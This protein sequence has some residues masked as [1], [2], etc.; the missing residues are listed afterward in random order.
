[1]TR[2]QLWADDG[3]LDVGPDAIRL[4]RQG[5]VEEVFPIS[6]PSSF[7]SEFKDFYTALVEGTKP[8][9]T[10]QDALQDL[11]VVLAAHQS[12]LTNKVIALDKE[13]QP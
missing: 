10:A 9:M 7:V 2:I 5:Q 13:Q 11:R 3:T 12:S 1:M 4:Q 8:Q 6:G